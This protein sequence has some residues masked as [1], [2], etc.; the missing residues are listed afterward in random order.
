MTSRGR[1]NVATTSGSS[2][3]GNDTQRRNCYQSVATTTA[4]KSNNRTTHSN[5]GQVVTYCMKYGRFLSAITRI[6]AGT[7][8]TTSRLFRIT[9]YHCHRV[10]IITIIVVIVKYYVVTANSRHHNNKTIT[11]VTIVL[12]Y[13][14]TTN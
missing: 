12:K 9:R 4:S 5:C 10:I 11:A 13:T 1:H 6:A 2:E 8:L 14:I 7:Q 3:R